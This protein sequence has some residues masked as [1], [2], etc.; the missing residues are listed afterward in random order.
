MPYLC[1]GRI[2]VGSQ[3]SANGSRSDKRMDYSKFCEKL[4]ADVRIGVAKKHYETHPDVDKWI[5]R[6]EELESA[7]PLE[8]VDSKAVSLLP[9]EGV[10]PGYERSDVIEI[11]HPEP[12]AHFTSTTAPWSSS[13]TV[14]GSILAPDEAQTVKASRDFWARGKEGWVDQAGAERKAATDRYRG[15]LRDNF[16]R[17]SVLSSQHRR[18]EADRSAQRIAKRTMKQNFRRDIY[19]ANASTS[20]HMGRKYAGAHNKCGLS[21]RALSK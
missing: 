19:E 11:E 16:A 8:H 18:A 15:A 20:S 5:F 12:P 2:C 1:F 9:R 10:D 7:H 14:M 13:H 4:H 17:Q 6:Q 21:M 3:L